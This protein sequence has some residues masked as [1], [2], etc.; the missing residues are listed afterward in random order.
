MLPQRHQNIKC[1]W[2]LSPQN[3]TTSGVAKPS[4]LTLRKWHAQKTFGCGTDLLPILPFP[5][6]QF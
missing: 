6:L 3:G 1:F 4:T 2:A 5:P